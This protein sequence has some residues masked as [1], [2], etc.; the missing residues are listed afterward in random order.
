MCKDLKRY[1]GKINAFSINQ[2]TGYSLM[3][4]A[5]LIVTACI[6]RYQFT[7]CLCQ[8]ANQSVNNGQ[9]MQE[10]VLAGSCS[11]L[12]CVNGLCNTARLT[13]QLD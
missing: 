5:L 7:V 10:E 9:C 12:F 4:L 6:F 8:I 3:N 1:K 13:T 11:R 2:S